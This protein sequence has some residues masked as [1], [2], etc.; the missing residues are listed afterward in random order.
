M[1][2]ISLFLSIIELFAMHFFI[3]FTYYIGIPITKRVFNNRFNN[4][5]IN[6]K[7]KMN[8]TGILKYRFV[9]TNKVLFITTYSTSE[10]ICHTPFPYKSICEILPN[11]T[12]IIRNIMPIGSFLFLFFITLNMILII[13]YSFFTYKNLSLLFIGLFFLS[14]II[15]FTIFS[16]SYENKLFRTKKDILVKLLN[17]F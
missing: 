1:S 12:L 15:V 10:K 9:S 13:F 7:K 14:A 8:K 2:I 5:E 16:L 11:E 17:D 6:K 4:I 3:H